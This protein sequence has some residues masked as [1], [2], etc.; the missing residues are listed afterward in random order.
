MRSTRLIPILVTNDQVPR[1][2]GAGWTAGRGSK[3]HARAVCTEL[4]VGRGEEPF[5]GGYFPREVFFFFGFSFGPVPLS[6]PAVCR[7]CFLVAIFPPP[8][9]ITTRVAVR[10][11]HGR[12][13]ERDRCA[14]ESGNARMVQTP[15]LPRNAASGGETRSRLRTAAT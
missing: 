8:G 9:A 5:R 4:G 2:A 11:S 12:M 15:V 13:V 1:D 6:V 7:F 14:R 3:K 10:V